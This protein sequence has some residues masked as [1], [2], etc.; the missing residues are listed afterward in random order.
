MATK[1][2]FTAAGRW[3]LTLGAKVQGEKDTVKGAVVF[4]AKE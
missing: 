4:T 2:D 1:A 3:Q